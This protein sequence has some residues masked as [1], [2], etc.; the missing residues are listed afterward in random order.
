MVSMHMESG[1]PS[2]EITSDQRLEGKSQKK[3]MGEDDSMPHEQQEEA[4]VAFEEQ[5]KG[6]CRCSGGRQEE[7]SRK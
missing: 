4:F 1:K 2:D 7:S 5:H 6:Q 3:Y